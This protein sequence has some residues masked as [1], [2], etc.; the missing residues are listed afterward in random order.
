MFEKA[1]RLGDTERSIALETRLGTPIKNLIETHPP[2]FYCCNKYRLT[3]DRFGAD[4]K[5]RK[6]ATGIYNC[7]GHV[8]ASRR[9]SILDPQLMKLILEEDGYRRLAPGEKPCPGD[10]A[11]YVDLD[12]QDEILHVGRVYGFERG[13]ADGSPPIPL[14]ISKWDSTSGESLHRAHDVHY[15][16]LGFCFQ[17]RYYTDRPEQAGNIDDPGSFARIAV[18]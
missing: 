6:P 9:T 1:K 5:E 2:P 10:I 17:I 11:V 4:W 13:L 16:S 14:I 3:V 8:W 15:G 12:A 18:Q 7:A